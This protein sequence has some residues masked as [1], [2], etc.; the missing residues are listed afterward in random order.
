MDVSGP[1]GNPEKVREP[2]CLGLGLRGPSA[3]PSL[4]LLLSCN[5]SHPVLCHCS[6]WEASLMSP[7]LWALLPFI[8][9]L[10]MHAV[11]FGSGS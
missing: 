9:V 3:S 4:S 11:D 8:P 1:G 10:S 7:V 5:Y 6:S 2:C